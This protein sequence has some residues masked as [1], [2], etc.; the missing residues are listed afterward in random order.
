MNKSKNVAVLADRWK[1]EK[2][3]QADSVKVT[4][5]SVE[6]LTQQIKAGGNI[7]IPLVGFTDS[8]DVNV[9][10]DGM[11]E[12]AAN[13]IRPGIRSH[14]FDWVKTI[15]KPDG[16]TSDVGCKAFLDMMSKNIPEISVEEQESQEASFDYSATR[17]QY[18]ENG[19]EIF[20]IDKIKRQCII[21]GVDYGSKI[22]KYL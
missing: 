13:A 14:E 12:N 3:V 15:V 10:T 21:G 6:W 1:I 5:P 19:V 9:T 2:E 17:Y 16:T 8:L 20:L 22:E 7:D 11:T 18:F 4:L